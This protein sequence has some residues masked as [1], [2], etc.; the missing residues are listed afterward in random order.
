MI[1]FHHLRARVHVSK[2]LEPFPATSTL[3]RFFD[4]LMYAVGILAPLSLLPQILQ[5]YTT[6]SGVGLSL[7]TWSLFVLINLLWATYGAMHKDTHIFFAN[8][9]MMVF[10]LIVVVGILMY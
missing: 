5:I 8:I 1:G 4:Y 6:E 7:S 2:G 3:K 10:N 9:F